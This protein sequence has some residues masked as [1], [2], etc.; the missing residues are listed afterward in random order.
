MNNS[1]SYNN[2]GSAAKEN[3]AAKAEG[4]DDKKASGPKFYDLNSSGPYL[5]DRHQL[6][7]KISSLQNK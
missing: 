3:A 6:I 2:E 5:E 7:Q 4:A 1:D